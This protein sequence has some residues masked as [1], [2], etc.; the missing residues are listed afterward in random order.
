MEFRRVS[1]VPR[2]VPLGRDR[3]YEKYYWLDGIGTTPVINSQGQPQYLVGRLFVQGC[4]EA[5]MIEMEDVCEQPRRWKDVQKRIPEEYGGEE[6]ML[7]RNQWAVYSN[8][9][10]VSGVPAA[11]LGI[12][13]T[14]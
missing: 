2:L 10:E 12:R 1:L 14:C 8:P 5:E 6:G 7:E 11:A 3:F 13:K 4:S 9:D